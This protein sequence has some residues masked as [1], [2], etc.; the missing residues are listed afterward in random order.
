VPVPVT[1]QP[2]AVRMESLSPFEVWVAV[3]SA[4]VA[5]RTGGPSS[6][7]TSAAAVGTERCRY[8]TLADAVRAHPALFAAPAP[9]A[10]TVTIGAR[11]DHPLLVGV[12]EFSIYIPAN[13]L[14]MF[15]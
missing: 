12:R 9:G 13:P 4:A 5:A 14:S 1:S 11:Y 3:P 8:P 10:H 7:T 6:P 2:H 15:R